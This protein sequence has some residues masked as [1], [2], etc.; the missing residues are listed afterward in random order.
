MNSGS[1]LCINRALAKKCYDR[2]NA[3]EKYDCKGNCFREKIIREEMSVVKFS[4][5]VFGAC[6]MTLNNTK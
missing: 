2:S 1:V 4:S 3:H 5:L 6:K